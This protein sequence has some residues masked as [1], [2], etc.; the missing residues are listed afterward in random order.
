MTTSVLLVHGGLWDAMDAD[1]FWGTPGVTA[2]VIAALDPDG[3]GRVE[4]LAPDRPQ[5][6]TGWDLEVAALGEYLA[7]RSGPVRIVGASNGCTVAVL[8][9]TRFPDVVDRLMLAWPATGDDPAGNERARA[10]MMNRGC[11]ADVADGLLRGGI[12]RGVQDRELA[13]LTQ[14][15]VAVLPSVPEN[16]SHQRKTVDALLRSIRGSHELAGCPEPPVPGFPP[17]LDQLARTIVE[18]VN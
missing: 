2:A 18:F 6:A 7:K 15:R 5:R 10:G 4:V 17:F 9:A 13:S 8:L 16:P 3:S 1:A 12:L 14:T 11:P